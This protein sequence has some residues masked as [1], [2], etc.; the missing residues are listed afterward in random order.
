MS[1]RHKSIPLPPPILACIV[2][3]LAAF[4][5]AFTDARL[6]AIPLALFLIVCLAAPF[7][8][9]FSFY[10]PV[11]SH[12]SSGKKAVAVSFDDG[13][14]PATT[15]ALLNLLKKHGTSAT[16]F[17]TGRR[18][19]EHR[20]L[21]RQILSEGHSI[22]NHSYNHSPL[23]MLKSYSHLLHD[24]Q[25]TQAL[26]TEFG[27]TPLVFRPP[28]GITSPR[29]GPALAKTG[30][31]CVNFSCRGYDAGNR[32]I[33]RLSNKILTKAKPDDIILLHDCA[34]NE[35]FNLNNYLTEIESIL[36]GMKKKGLEILPLSEIIGTA[37]MKTWP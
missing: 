28:V 9:G 18:A 14:D 5:L 16:F 34:P 6:C 27:I 33:R 15:P 8:P 31:L 36:V 1:R 25:S 7:F 17:V 37:V 30:L 3:Y 11:V 20:G 21:V 26:L 12:G 29:L 2:A 10:L 4:I 22:G 13:P 24:I 23:L 19:S 35:N 32:F